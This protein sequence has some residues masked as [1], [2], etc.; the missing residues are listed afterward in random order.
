M[1]EASKV[2]GS[3][4]VKM[5]EYDHIGSE[6]RM[7]TGNCVVFPPKKVNT[8]HFLSSFPYPNALMT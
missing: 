8:A 2:F 1:M 5:Q 4:G 7:Q 3:C 6:K